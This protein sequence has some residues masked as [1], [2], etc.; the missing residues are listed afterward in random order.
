MVEYRAP[1]FK[2]PFFSAMFDTRMEKFFDPIQRYTHEDIIKKLSENKLVVFDLTRDQYHAELRF[3][4]VNDIKQSLDN[5]KFDNII[6]L[7]SEIEYIDKEEDRI[8]FCPLW[9]FSKHIDY[10]SIPY[11]LKRQRNYNLSC[12]NRFPFPHKIYTIFKLNEMGYDYN[13]ILL[14]CYGLR[15]PYNLQRQLTISDLWDIPK[16][17]KERIS[18]MELYK[19]CMPGDNKWNNDHSISHPA[20]SD[21]YLN[22]ITESTYCISF[23]TEKTCKPL[24]A[25]QLFLSANGAESVKALKHFGF[26]C[27]ED[28][29][30]NHDYENHKDF[31]QRIDNMIKLLNNIYPR[32]EELYWDNIDRLEYNRNYFISEDFKNTILQ[33]L[34]KKELI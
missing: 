20:F 24:A 8:L 21:S 14:S 10:R 33:P 29:F 2:V 19:E 1:E 6:Y 16:D 3:Q 28:L 4:T 13:K 12:L 7:T 31:I 30:N 17:I 11:Q 15:D 9:F 5:L 32:I 27:F 34:I 22:I 26:E 23:F 18:K 25:G